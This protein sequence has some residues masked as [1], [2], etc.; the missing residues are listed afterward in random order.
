MD[1]ELRSER[2]LGSAVILLDSQTDYRTVCDKTS[3][4]VLFSFLFVSFLFSQ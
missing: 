1:F 4:F 2:A 3:L